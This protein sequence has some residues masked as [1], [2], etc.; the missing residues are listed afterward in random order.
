MAEAYHDGYDGG[1][2][3]GHGH[4]E[5]DGHSG[6]AGDEGAGE[7]GYRGAAGQADVAEEGVEVAGDVGYEA[8]VLQDG[9]AEGYGYHYL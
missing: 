2:A 8:V 9:D 5:H 1:L 6:I 4:G 3:Q 7:E